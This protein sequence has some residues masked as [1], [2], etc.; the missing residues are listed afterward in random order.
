ML[1][2]RGGVATFD[3]GSGHEVSWKGTESSTSADSFGSARENHCV[4]GL[5]QE[6]LRGV[7]GAVSSTSTSTHFAGVAREDLC[8]LEVF[9]GRKKSVIFVWKNGTSSRT[10]SNSNGVLLLTWQ[11]EASVLL[12]FRD[13]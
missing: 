11:F 12:S 2:L 4:Q 5:V 13:E 1:E 8:V 3:S 7:V 9:A 6:R 10:S